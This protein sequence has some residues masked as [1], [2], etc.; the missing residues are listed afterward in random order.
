M[1]NDVSFARQAQVCIDWSSFL[2][3]G[4]QLQGCSSV[5]VLSELVRGGAS[6]IAVE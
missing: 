6:S 3:L 1:V 4:C 2:S 5:R